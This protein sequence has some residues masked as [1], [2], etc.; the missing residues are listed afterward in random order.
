MPRAKPRQS[1]STTSAELV[2][3]QAVEDQPT[4]GRLAAAPSSSAKRAAFLVAGG[5]LAREAATAL[6]CF[7][8][9][10]VPLVDAAL[11]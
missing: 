4:V 7:L 1:L 11:T 6:R 9:E 10:I 5:R 8:D 2:P 3:D